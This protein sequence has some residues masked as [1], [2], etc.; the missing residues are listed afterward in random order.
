MCKLWDSKGKAHTKLSAH[1]GSVFWAAYNDKCTKIVT[2]G[3]D[4]MVYV[5]DCKKTA[6]PLLKC[7]GNKSIVRSV[8]FLNNDKHI[9]STSL[10]GEI[11]IFD[12]ASGD[13]VLQERCL[14]DKSDLEGNT[15]Y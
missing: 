8:G 5:W 14:G 9:I 11:T 12:A 1:K 3:V 7:V 15:I 2:G 6:K 13:V 10:E 4:K